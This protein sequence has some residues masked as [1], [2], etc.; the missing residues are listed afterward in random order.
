MRLY[1]DPI[2]NEF[3]LYL[4]MGKLIVQINTGQI[5]YLKVIDNKMNYLDIPGQNRFGIR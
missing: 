1:L 2:D 4:E 3:Y 5:K